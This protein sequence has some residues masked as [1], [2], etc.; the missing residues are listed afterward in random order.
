MLIAETV[1]PPALPAGLLSVTCH[2]CAPW[3][4]V[5]IV[6]SFTSD[7]MVADS[8]AATADIV[9]SYT[10][11]TM[12]CGLPAAT[13]LAATEVVTSPGAAMLPVNV[14]PTVA[15]PEIFATTKYRRGATVGHTFTG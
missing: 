1:H 2:A 7:E 14:C 9:R 5:V 15:P 13:P 3:P 11:A 10:A 12:V 6:A 4:V 8:L